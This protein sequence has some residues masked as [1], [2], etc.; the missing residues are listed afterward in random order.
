MRALRLAVMTLLIVMPFPAQNSDDLNFLSGLD[1]FERVREMLPSYLK[2]HAMEFL[3]QR[4]KQVAQ[5]STLDD[6][7][8]RKAYV[9]EVMVRGLG[10]FPERTPLN[11]RVT[12]TL[13]RGDYR[14]EKII[15][16]SQPHFYVT[17]NLYLPVWKTAGSRSPA[18]IAPVGHWL[19]GK[20]FE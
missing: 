18:F 17:A 10:G 1:E 16:E 12:G 20:T 9:R 5:L 6:L 14:I 13:D 8:R 3:E 19:E 2:R 7:A 4:E 11:A 15:F